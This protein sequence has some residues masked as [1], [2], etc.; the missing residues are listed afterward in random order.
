MTATHKAFVRAWLE[1][2]DHDLITAQ[3]VL[4]IEP[5]ILDTAC[6]HCQQAVEKYLKAFLAYHNCRIEK[7]HNIIFLLSQ[8]SAIDPVFTT[9][10]P[11][12]INAYAVQSR[13]PD[14]SIVPDVDEAKDYYQLAIRVN[15]L[16]R[17]RLIFKDD[18]P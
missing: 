2:A 1:K 12:N 15:G 4:E 18:Q 10:D 7:T 6:F 3:R 5:M 8:C 11:L 17:E 9:V 14:D 16:V 13:Y